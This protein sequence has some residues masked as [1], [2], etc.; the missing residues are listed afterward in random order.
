M[1]LIILYGPPAVG[2]LTV[3]KELKK[4]MNY[5]LLH[6]HL[7]VDLVRSIFDFGTKSFAVLNT[8]LREYVVEYAAKNNI[9]GLIVTLTYVYKE[10]DELI[11]RLV[12]LVEEY[13]GE[14]KFV[15]LVCPKSELLRRASSVSRK[16]FSKITSKK[17]LNEL[18][19]RKD[20]FSKIPGQKSFSIET[21]NTL[22]R[23]VAGKVK[24]FYNL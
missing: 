23:E 4:L 8:K 1:K 11:K 21:T 5:K 15:Q 12:S 13:G 19:E 22:P 14:V 2:K 7:I 17:E 18:L 20:F 6:S 24:E 3:S 9:P 16:K 10:D